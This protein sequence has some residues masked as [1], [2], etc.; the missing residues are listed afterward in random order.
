MTR[1]WKASYTHDFKILKFP[2]NSLTEM[3]K[4]E[5]SWHR[6]HLWHFK[7]SRCPGRIRRE[8]KLLIGV[9][10]VYLRRWLNGDYDS[11]AFHWCERL[12][13]G[14]QWRGEI[15]DAHGSFGPSTKPSSFTWLHLRFFQS[16][17]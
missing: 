9:R 16:N 12:V 7:N 3:A 17:Q 11:C 1:V 10:E 15:A 2:N 14:V 4:H 6:E 13:Q 8:G 5:A